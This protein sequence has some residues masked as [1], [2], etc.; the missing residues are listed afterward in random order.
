MLKL[1]KLELKKNKLS[2]LI[3]TALITDLIIIGII[4]LLNFT[5]DKVPNG[6]FTDFMSEIP[7]ID[8]MVRDIFIIFAS[9]ML[10]RFIID[11]FKNRTITVLF[12]YPVNRKKLMISKIIIV[13]VFT[14]ISIIVGDILTVCAAGIYNLLFNIIPWNVSIAALVKEIVNI[15]IYALTASLISLIPLYFGMRKKSV[16]ATILSSV[17]LVS[18]VGSKLDY[19]SLFS[20]IAI[21]ITLSVIAVI[22]VYF[23]IRNVENV[24]IN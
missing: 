3:R 7:M 4:L 21:P 5:S 19:I 17:I 18:L 13:V 22:I 1:M 14:F 15:F 2:G 24:D 9:V 6:G 8:S 20:F 23:T 12:S 16:P 10:A 11:E